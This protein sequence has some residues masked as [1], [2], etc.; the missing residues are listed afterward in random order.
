MTKKRSSEIFG[1][2]MEIFCGKNIMFP[3]PP[4]L[5]ARSPPLQQRFLSPV[6]PLVNN[7]LFHQPSFYWK[8]IVSSFQLLFQKV[9][10]IF[11]RG[12]G[13]VRGARPLPPLQNW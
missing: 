4:K 11:L 3:R 6:Q 12:G 5:G 2:K 9:I 13:N 10:C 8:N 7:E 1:L